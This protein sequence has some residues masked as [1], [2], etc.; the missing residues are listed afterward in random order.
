MRLRDD[1]SRKGYHSNPNLTSTLMSAEAEEAAAAAHAAEEGRCRSLGHQGGG[2]DTS[3]SSAAGGTA[4]GLAHQQQHIG[5]GFVRKWGEE[6]YSHDGDDDAAVAAAAAAAPV[7]ASVSGAD[8]T[9]LVSHGAVAAA[10]A[11]LR[12]DDPDSRRSSDGD[13]GNIPRRAVTESESSHPLRDFSAEARADDGVDVG[14]SAG[15]GGG[16]GGRGNT[17]IP[18]D[19]R[20][21][22]LVSMGDDGRDGLGNRDEDGAIGGGSGGG[23][24]VGVGREGGLGHH[25]VGS[26]DEEF[27]EEELESFDLRVVY[28]KGRTGFQESKAF[29][30][31]EG[32][33]VAG[34]YEVC[35][36]VRFCMGKGG[37]LRLR[38]PMCWCAEIRRFIVAEEWRAWFYSLSTGQNRTLA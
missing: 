8:D 21:N 35:Q 11:A 18:R 32:S 12:V 4:I 38:V 33:L 28:A 9:T 36:R 13:A 15:S 30:W 25:V 24:G 31:P 20:P 14:A 2:R 1:G 37:C 16:G 29:D 6:K 22:S 10:A 27:E 7:A 3:S 34:R 5:G 17:N 23:G 19:L 26:H